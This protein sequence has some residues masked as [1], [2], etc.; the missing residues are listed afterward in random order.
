MKTEKNILIAFLLNFA[1]SIFEC[2]GGLLTGSVAILSDA[3]H[4]IGD[5]VSIGAA[6]FFERKSKGQ[7]DEKYTYGYQRL[8]V[9]GSLLT[10]VILLVGSVLVLYNAVSR[11]I[12]PIAIHYDGMILFAVVGTAVNLCAAFFTRKG[13]SLN[14][15][16]VNLH[17]FEDSLGWLVVLV[18]AIVMRFTDFWWIDPILS[19]GVSIFIGV[20]AVKTLSETLEVF[21]ET[22]PRGISVSALKKHL[23]EIDGVV[24]V[25]HLH[26]WSLDGQSGCATLHAVANGNAHE[27]KEKIREELKEHGV[28][29]VTIEIEQEGEHCRGRNC[30]VVAASTV[31]C[32]HHHHH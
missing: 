31:C 22:A 27:V 9:L 30:Q 2:I 25:H 8:S 13:D 3:V 14:Q 7:P 1:F 29:H 26:L 18:G 16:A 4:D 10:T 32:H 20:H 11:L 21:L 19:I 6:Y 15:K 17:M 24:E 5:A 28:L 23:E 12:T